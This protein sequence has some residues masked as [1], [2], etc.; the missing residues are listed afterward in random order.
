MLPITSEYSESSTSPN[1]QSALL[2]L[3]KMLTVP[4]LPHV[5]SLF[6]DLLPLSPGANRDASYPLFLSLQHQQTCFPLCCRRRSPDSSSVID[7]FDSTR[8]LAQPRHLRVTIDLSHP[9]PRPH[10]V[11]LHCLGS[12]ESG[13][14][15]QSRSTWI[16]LPQWICLSFDT[17]CLA[18]HNW[19]RSKVDMNRATRWVLPGLV[20]QLA[21]GSV[22]LERGLHISF[23]TSFPVEVP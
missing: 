16:H 8:T 14:I 17:L 1:N 19:Q 18:G 7:E 5:V 2:S 22:S 6:V 23:V 3:W 21:A 4:A 20:F 12:F 13:L 11:T 9:R 15:P 10:H